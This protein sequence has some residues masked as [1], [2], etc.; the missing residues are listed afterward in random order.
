VRRATLITLIVLFSLL[1]GATIW[2]LQLAG[3]DHGPLPG[4]TSP[5][6]LPSPVP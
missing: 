2:Q 3:Q 5:G 1:A 6:Q 4:P